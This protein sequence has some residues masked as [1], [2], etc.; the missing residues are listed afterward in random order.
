MINE[1]YR[2]TFSLF[3]LSTTTVTKA[4]KKSIIIGTV[5]VAL[6]QF[7][8]TF[9]LL[10]YTAS[11]FKKSGATTISPE[12]ATIIVGV[13][14]LVGAYVSTFMVDRAG[15]KILICSSSLGV[16]LGMTTFGIATQL[17]EHNVESEF[18]KIIP[19]IALSLSV[20]SANVGVFSLTFVVLSEISPS[21]VSIR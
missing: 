19:V 2:K 1:S 8:G 15:R 5:L 3:L 14:Q 18:I 16:A 10:F 9:A 6:E 7:T 13:I 12:I 17:L 4:A 21:N 20:F 11:I